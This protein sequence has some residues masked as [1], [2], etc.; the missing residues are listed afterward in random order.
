V[1]QRE[2]IRK[3]LV[4]VYRVPGWCLVLDE[5]A[6][7]ARDLGLERSLNANWREGRSKRTTVVAGTQRPVN[8][9]RNMWENATHFI[10][11]RISGKEDRDTATGY[12]GE[13]QGVAFETV[14]LLP[15]YEF[16]YVDKVEGIAMRSRVEL[17]SNVGTAP[18][19]GDRSEPA[20][21]DAAA[22]R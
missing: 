19:A 12:L 11:F 13:L 21:D 4:D 10:I 6:Y 8:V 16:L 20:G 7:L 5:V 15:R 18:R 3:V 2:Q 9:P 17:G 22:S 1:R 14:K